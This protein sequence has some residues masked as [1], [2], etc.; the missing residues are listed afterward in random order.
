MLALFDVV[1]T[2]CC[3]CCVATD[4]FDKACDISSADMETYPTGTQCRALRQYVKPLTNIRTIH[5]YNEPSCFNTLL[6]LVMHFII[7]KYDT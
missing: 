5:M 7:I 4:R 3:G 2:L 6:K 1:L